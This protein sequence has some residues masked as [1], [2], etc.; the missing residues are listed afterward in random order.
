MPIH[1]ARIVASEDWAL[2]I[3]TD[4]WIPV[5]NAEAFLTGK[6]RWTVCVDWALHVWTGMLF[7][8]WEPSFF[9]GND[10]IFL[11]KSSG[12]AQ[13]VVLD[14]NFSLWTSTI[15][16]LADRS[17]RADVAWMTWLAGFSNHG[18]R[19]TMTLDVAEFLQTFAEPTRIA[20]WVVYTQNRAITCFSRLGS[21]MF[22]SIVPDLIARIGAVHL[23]IDSE[24]LC[25]CH[26]L[27]YWC[28]LH[29]VFLLFL[30]FFF[31]FKILFFTFIHPYAFASL[32][33]SFC[34]AYANSLTSGT[35]RSIH[36]H[37]SITA[38]VSRLSGTNADAEN[39][40][41]KWR[42]D[43]LARCW[44]HGCSKAD[45]IRSTRL[46]NACQIGGAWWINALI[47]KKNHGRWTL[48][49]SSES[50]DGFTRAS[51]GAE[52]VVFAIFER[53]GNLSFTVAVDVSVG[54]LHSRGIHHDLLEVLRLIWAVLLSQLELFHGS[55]RT[56]PIFCWSIE[57]APTELKSADGV[58]KANYCA[59][60]AVFAW[61]GE[62][63]VVINEILD[64]WVDFG[65][66]R[67]FGYTSHW[68]FWDEDRVIVW[69]MWNQRWR[70]TFYGPNCCSSC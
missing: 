30:E 23:W 44:A 25:R 10:V 24:G 63:Y 39:L 55:W 47:V 37:R 57:R 17:R 13:A 16:F 60:R 52:L 18:G 32:R 20:E 14:E 19:N 28:E 70:E 56:N 5:T 66:R 41:M 4:W 43:A 69:L 3:Q 67:C 26:F 42:A 40:T 2:Q 34:W 36:A 33:A 6:M 1:V 15:V 51:P 68:L 45:S 48:T 12:D 58:A 7:P 54:V 53:L 22:M 38:I 46:Q 35:D 8:L 64:Q 65:S 49:D 27:L 29:E 61:H 11:A 9:F 21:T 31:Q 62:L 59:I 50:I